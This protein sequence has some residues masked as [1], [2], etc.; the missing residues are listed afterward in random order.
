MP[1]ESQSQIEPTR[2]MWL[3]VARRA[4]YGLRYFFH[5][6]RVYPGY[7]AG[8]IIVLT[9]ALV[10]IAAPAIA[11]FSPINADATVYLNRQP[12]HIFWELIPPGWMFSAE[13]S[14]RPA[15]T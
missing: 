1:V 12:G 10:S 11:P 5:F 7:A 6:L 9:V 3:L 2:A 13:L 4:A 15:S 14:L 8:Y